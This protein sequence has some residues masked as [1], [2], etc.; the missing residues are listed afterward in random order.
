MPSYHLTT[1]DREYAQD[2]TRR[3]KHA[4]DNLWELLLEAWNS[5]A[6]ISMGYRSWNAYVDAEFDFSRQQSYRLVNQGQVIK[7][8]REAASL[9][10]N[11]DS[12]GVRVSEWEAR[13]IS[14]S[15]HRG[16]GAVVHPE[17]IEHVQEQVS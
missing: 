4:A 17:V 16:Q 2:L 13:H 5:K 7:Q 6:H 11:G 1:A 3:I 8:L 12:S 15:H 10:P 9:S 14:E